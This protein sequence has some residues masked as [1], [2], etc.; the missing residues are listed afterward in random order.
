[1]QKYTSADRRQRILQT[2]CAR[3]LAEAALRRYRRCRIIEQHVE[4]RMEFPSRNAAEKRPVRMKYFS[5]V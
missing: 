3:A 1:L 2:G 4:S 5:R